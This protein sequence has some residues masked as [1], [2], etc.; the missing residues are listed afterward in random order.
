MKCKYE[1]CFTTFEA[2]FIIQMIGP[3]TVD[4][5]LLVISFMILILFKVLFSTF[6]F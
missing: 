4:M 5:F 3:F 2:L 1:K 6:E